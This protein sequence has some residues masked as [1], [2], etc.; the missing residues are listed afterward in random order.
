MSKHLVRF[1]LLCTALFLAS[2]ESSQSIVNQVDEREA[3]E[4]VVYLASKGIA[5]QKVVASTG[6][7]GGTAP[8]NLFSIAVA[9]DQIGRAHV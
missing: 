1:F 3:N 8:S 9:P 7:M 4:I 5:A 2:C 6:E